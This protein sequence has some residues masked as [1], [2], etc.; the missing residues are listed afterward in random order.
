[1]LAM[2][3]VKKAIDLMPRYQKKG[4]FTD[5]KMENFLKL[6]IED[7][8]EH[9]IV[10]QENI[11]FSLNLNN[12]YIMSLIIKEFE[13]NDFTVEPELYRKRKNIIRI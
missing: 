7:Q 1:M 3:R 5:R 9:L 10:E 12:E 2:I 8:R 13:E 11:L 6:P 4:K